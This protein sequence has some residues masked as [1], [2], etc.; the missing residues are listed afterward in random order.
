MNL[1]TYAR[2]MMR[3][4]RI[5]DPMDVTPL[6]GGMINV[7]FEV[8]GRDRKRFIVQRL[9]PVFNS[10]TVEDQYS[11]CRF[12]T[13]NGISVPEIIS[14]WRDEDGRTWKIS[15]AI[16]YDRSITQNPETIRLAAQ[17]LSNVHKALEKCYYVSF[18]TLPDFHNTPVILGKLQE[19]ILTS[20]EK[21]GIGEDAEYVLTASKSLSLPEAPLSFIHGDPKW[22]NFLFSSYPDLHVAALIDWDTV[23]KGNPFMDVGD[24]VRSFCKGENGAFRRDRFESIVEG[25]GGKSDF[26]D[27]ALVAAKVITLELAARF[28]I[29]VAEDSYFDFDRS[30]FATRRDSNIAS[31]KKYIDYFRSM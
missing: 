21:F 23:M 16:P 10:G 27:K 13:N 8:I 9:H 18:P 1:Q 11:V 26:K 4:K 31:A 2:E 19:A 6:G 30:K 28:L 29:D 15:R 7:T 22:N 24:M 25:Y 3:R 20:T 17:Y 12:L 14:W 5:C